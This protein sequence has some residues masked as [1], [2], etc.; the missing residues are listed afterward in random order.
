MTIRDRGLQ[1]PDAHFLSHLWAGANTLV[2]T[3]P[4]VSA[5]LSHALRSSTSAQRVS[6]L[7]QRLHCEHCD[8][9]LTLS[10]VRV[11][12]QFK[13]TRRS[14]NPARA[15]V[16]TCIACSRASSVVVA[17]RPEVE[18]Q[19]AKKR[20][21]KTITPKA[22]SSSR[23]RTR[24]RRSQLSSTPRT[25]QTP[26]PPSTPWTPRT[27]RTPSTGGLQTASFLFEPL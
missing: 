3:A 27:P 13:R 21:V 26:Q 11:R 2:A 7:V 5:H 24:R 18:E 1:A 12:S 10:K 19:R 6:R 17:T 9:L 4:T 22:S 15:V 8:A 16:R 25:P 23:K 20:S 14:P